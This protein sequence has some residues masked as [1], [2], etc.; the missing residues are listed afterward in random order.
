MF[1]ARPTGI[2]GCL[3]IFGPVFNDK[4][5]LFVKTLHADAFSNLG[6]E[7][8]FAEEYY[9]FSLPRVLRGLHFQVPPYDH[10]KI[11]CCAQG[12]VMDAVVDLRR[13]SPTYGKY[14]IFRLSPEKGNMVYIPP[15]LAHGYYVTGT[16][17]LMLY[18]VTTAYSPDHDRGVSWN[19]AGIPWPDDSPVVS[20]RDAGFPTLGEFDSPFVF[21]P[22]TGFR[23]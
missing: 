10:L 8:N 13:G 14:D 21:I 1:T 22:P 9:T 6:L 16:G 17:A 23:P 4:R 20:D 18:K 5:G 2:P 7:R 12:E 11:V 3:E 19:S 15:G